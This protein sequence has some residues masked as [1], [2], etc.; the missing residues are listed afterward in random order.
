MLDIHTHI[1]P[2]MDDGSRSVEQSLRML[3]SEVQQGVHAVAL[4]P[5]YNA[6]RESPTGFLQRRDAAEQKLRSAFRDQREFVQLLCGAE[7]AYFDGMCR[8]EEID[9]LCIGNT[10]VMLIEMPFCKWSRR[11]VRELQELRQLRGIQPVMAHVERYRAF[12]PRGWVDEL[13]EQGMLIQVNTSFFLRW[14]TSFVALSMLK[15]Q[16]IHFVASDC[17][18][19]EL[20]KPDLG[21]AVQRMEKY[22]G[23]QTTAFLRENSR[24]L[25][26]G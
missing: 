12:Q 10:N 17:H 8:A 1:L 7:V 26:G 11:M 24:K 18:N 23:K 3:A 2:G 9:Q 20:R 16:R 15:K 14:Q 22:A 5:H 21:T 13:I 6:G 25:L 19:M 4:T